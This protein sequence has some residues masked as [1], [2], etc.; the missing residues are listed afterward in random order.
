MDHR[1]RFVFSGPGS[2]PL[3]QAIDQGAALGFSRV[4]FNADNPANYPGTFTPERVRQVRA[5]AAQ[6]GITL[7]IH[8]LS[9]VNMA[10]ITPVMAAAADAYVRENVELAAALGATHLVVHGGFHFSSDVDARFA[11]AIARLKLA[12]QLAE[13]HAV[14]LHFE[15]HNAE[16]EHAEIRYI[17]HT[18]A[19]MRRML[20]GIAAPSP[21]WAC[22]VGHAMLVPDGFEGFLT[23][24]GA[25]RIG[26]VRLHD[27]NGLWEE[28]FR[29]GEGGGIVDFRH[30][31]TMLTR[32][33]YRGPFSIDFGRPEEK[34][35]WRDVWSAMLAE[36]G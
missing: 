4:D 20:D 36:I 6:H 1:T 29:P 8:T 33:G 30:V 10:E 16:P 2:W 23:A 25:D 21:R 9:A 14:E 13:A 22:N 35:H 15:N 24:F 12:V 31:F 18:V 26:H 34:A 28:H 7:G 19:E 32:A 27:T 17:P 11:A 3:E 5:L